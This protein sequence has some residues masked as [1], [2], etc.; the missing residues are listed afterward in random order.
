[1][2]GQG[3]GCCGSFKKRQPFAQPGMCSRRCETAE[4]GCEEERLGLLMRYVEY[5]PRPAHL[6]VLFHRSGERPA[7]GGANPDPALA[8][9]V[10][11][12][13]IAK[14]GIHLQENLDLSRL[15]ADQVYQFAYIFV[16][17]PI[18][19]GTGSPGSP[20]AVR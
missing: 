10:H 18:V 19:G 1:M 4:S 9:P 12:E 20:I 3:G 15:A 2:R 17:L 13:L 5:N 6:P 8:F 16:R 7:R 11:G 14:N